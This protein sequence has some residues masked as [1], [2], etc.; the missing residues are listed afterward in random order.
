MRR[1]R[2]ISY[3]IGLY[4]SSASLAQ[5]LDLKSDQPADQ[6]VENLY[7]KLDEQVETQY[8]K[9]VAPPPRT[10]PAKE[11][12]MDNLSD[13]A[14]LQAFE[15]IAVIQKRYL[16]KTHRFEISGLGFTNLNNPFFNNLGFGAKGTYHFSE[17][18]GIEGVANWFGVAARQ[19][20]KDL[21]EKAL[22]DAANTVTARSFLGVAAKWSPVYGKISLMNKSII[23]FDLSFSA[24]GGLTKTDVSGGE[25]TLHLGTSQNFAMSKA[26]AFRWDI[27]WNLYQANTVG[28]N[29]AKGKIAQNDLFIGLGVSLYIPEATYR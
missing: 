19:V 6:E 12:R 28:I 1:V 8:E 21:E 24:G 11:V 26:W 15:D 5:E 13:L 2:F 10:T 4:I 16:P 9:A 7:D 23:P 25:P 18:I 22:V 17:N 27:M 3:L 20:T 14:T 29:G